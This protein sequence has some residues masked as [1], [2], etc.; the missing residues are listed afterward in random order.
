MGAM[1][2]AVS[3]GVVG[4]WSAAKRL[5]ATSAQRTPR[6]VGHSLLDAEARS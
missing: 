3:L 6:P 4:R 5:L 1:A 2:I